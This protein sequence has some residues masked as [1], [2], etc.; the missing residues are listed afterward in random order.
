MLKFLFIFLTLVF[1]NSANDLD[2]KIQIKYKVGGEIITTTDIENERKYLVFLRP[3]LKNLSNDEIIKISENSLIRDMIKK[4]EIDKVFKDLDNKIIINEV[5]NKLISFKKVKNENEFRNL[6]YKA[7]I[8]YDK[9]IEKTKYE[10]FWNELIFQKYNSLIRID[11]KQLKYDL[12][13]K[14]SSNKKFEYNISELLFEIENNEN[15]NKKYD[16]I[17]AYI[18]TNNFKSAATRFSI[19]NSSSNGGNIG[20]IKETL[21][22]DNLNK[23][24]KNLKKNQITKPIKYPNG[25]LLLKINDK[26]ELKQKIDFD[27]EL[28][29]LINFEKNKQLNQFSLLFYKKLK[30]STI[31]NEY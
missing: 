14:I 10:A 3:D 6:L 27:R 19:S 24:L 13:T 8:D 30:Q 5:K 31:I 4:K 2:A 15:I 21:L 28:K 23:L 7:N 16:E 11:E 9:I 22:S 29:D 26:R 25:Y 17:I 1:L 12:K 18:K 20:W